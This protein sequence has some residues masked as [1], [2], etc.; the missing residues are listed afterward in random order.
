IVDAVHARVELVD[1][2][3]AVARA[4]SEDECERERDA[5]QQSLRYLHVGVTGRSAGV[6]HEKSRPLKKF[7]MTPTFA[8]ST[9]NSD[10]CSARAAVEEGARRLAWGRPPGGRLR[11][12]RRV[13]AFAR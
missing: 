10:A 8:G 9:V 12:A 3:S 1:L 4:G 7:E 5:L 2:Q 13:Q 11:S 6:A